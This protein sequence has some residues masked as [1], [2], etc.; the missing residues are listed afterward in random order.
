MARS[1]RIEDHQ[2]MLAKPQLLPNRERHT[3]SRHY[4]WDADESLHSPPSGASLFRASPWLN[5]SRGAYWRLLFAN[6]WK[7]LALVLLC[8]SALYFLYFFG[9][10][11]TGLLGP[12]EP[13][14]AAIGRAMARSGDW[15]TPRLWG[16][17]WFEKPALLY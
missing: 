3:R 14:Y 4:R 6:S 9:L 2:G 8:G 12:D 1:N 11:R 7:R 16:D 10:S 13:R 17:P 5:Y 15:V